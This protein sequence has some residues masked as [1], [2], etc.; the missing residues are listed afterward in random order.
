MF[1]Q[2]LLN[3]PKCFSYVCYVHNFTN[4]F[5]A[6]YAID[7]IPSLTIDAR[8]NL[9]YNAVSNGAYSAFKWVCPT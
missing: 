2:S 3:A 9:A 5:Y 1:I 4:T 8:A 6:L 7:F